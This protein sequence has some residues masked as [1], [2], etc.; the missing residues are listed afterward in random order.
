MGKGKHIGLGVAALAAGAGVAALAAGSHKNNGERAQKKAVEEKARAEYRNTERGRHEKNSKGIYYT[1]GNYE[2]FARPR[3]PEGVDEKSAYIVG[4]GLASLAAAC[5][6]VRDGQMEGS[7]IHILEAMD[8]AG[9]ACD[10]I[11]DPTRGYVMRGGREMENHFECL[12]DLFRSI[13]SIETPGVSVL[14]EYY[15]LNKEDPNFSLCRATEKQGQ[16]AHTDGKFAISDK[17]AMEIMHLFFTPDEQLYDKRITDVFDDE[18]F[19]S[20]FWMYWRTMFAFENWH[21][22]LE[23]KLYIKRF[24]HHIGGLP[25]FKALRFT[26]YNQY[27]SIILP[28]EKYLKEHGVQFHYATK[29]TDVRFDVTATRKQA[30][31]ITVEHDGQTDVID[32]TEND[33]LFITNGGCVESSTYG[34]QNTPAPFDPELKPGNGWDLWKKIAAQDASFGRPEKF[35]YDPEQSNWMSATVTT[36]DDK[37]P[38][39]IQKICKRDP[40]SGHTV[41]GGIVTVK[42]SSW[43]MSWTLNR[44]Q[45]FRDQPKNQLC[46][47]VYG[48]FSDK[49]GDY[50]KKPMRDCTG[51]E[52]CM[53]WLYHMGVPESEIEELAEHSANTVPVMMPY[54]TAFFMPRAAGDRPDVVPEG[55]VNFAFLGQFA[56]VPRDTIFTTEYSMRTAMVAVYTLLNVDRGVPEVWGSTYDIRDLLNATVQ[57]RDGKKI[58]DL[59]LP[60]MERLALKEVLKKISGT[61]I[62]KLLKEY[63]CI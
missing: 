39:Y 34:S 52:I 32:L 42:D 58:T 22:A 40:F 56:E 3:K 17:G 63:H 36:L 26:R 44:Q 4:S 47:W 8:I 2:A 50:V 18:V 33:L 16:D 49:P 14:D 55:A 54:I 28:M 7:H 27:E 12:W 1:N 10:G 53:E 31:S 5:F 20:N 19:S 59:D 25:D 35:C 60:L 57:L 43:L 41:T 24:I 23:M 62:E 15:W 30:S 48:L 13:P 11:N 38:Q 51:K 46:V 6:L 21:S 61:D 9:G 29:V 37:I 45:Q